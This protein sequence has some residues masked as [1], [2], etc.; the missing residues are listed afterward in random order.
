M[1]LKTSGGAG[2]G[3]QSCWK[4]NHYVKRKTILKCTLQREMLQDATM[5]QRT[6]AQSQGLATRI[7]AETP[8]ELLLQGGLWAL[9]SYGSDHIRYDELQRFL[10]RFK[11]QSQRA[12][13][14]WWLTWRLHMKEQCMVNPSTKLW[15]SGEK[16]RREAK[17]CNRW[18]FVNNLHD[19]RCL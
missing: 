10:C 11:C 13:N 3:R 7:P 12:R 18:Y 4:N 1:Q 2:R 8:A 14:S 9:W 17:P 15:F 19:E 6:Y 5:L 16:K